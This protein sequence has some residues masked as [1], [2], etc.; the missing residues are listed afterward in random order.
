MY[1][2]TYTL[3]LI[4]TKIFEF[5]MCCTSIDKLYIFTIVFGKYL[6][7]LLISGRRW[8]QISDAAMDKM[9][10]LTARNNIM[11]LW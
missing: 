1:R 4:G 11:H 7:Y 10:P 5:G 6:D 8:F 9:E 3:S 2:F